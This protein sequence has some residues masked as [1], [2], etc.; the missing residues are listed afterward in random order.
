MDTSISLQSPFTPLAAGREFRAHSSSTL[1][2][3]APPFSP[4][5]LASSRTYTPPPGYQSNLHGGRL[6]FIS[7][8]PSDV[9]ES[10]LRDIIDQYG[11]VQQ[12][13]FFYPALPY[14]RGSSHAF[15]I[16]AS[17]NDALRA[18][19]ILDGTD[20]GGNTMVVKV[21]PPGGIP[22]PTAT[23]LIT[24]STLGVVAQVPERPPPQTSIQRP[25]PQTAPKDLQ[26]SRTPSP[27]TS[28]TPAETQISK[29]ESSWAK[30]TGKDVAE[31]KS[32]SI[33]P[34][35]ESRR[36]S[37]GARFSGFVQLGRP[38][39]SMEHQCRVVFIINLPPKIT[40]QKVSDA[41]QEGPVASIRFGTNPEDNHPYVGIIF[42]HAT[43]ADSFH[44]VLKREQRDQ[45][46]R[47]F[48]FMP[49]VLRGEPHPTDSIIQSMGPP[50]FARRRLTI[51]KKGLFFKWGK[52]DLEAICHK[53]VGKDRVQLIFLYN[54]GNATVCFS[55]VELASKV[56][57]HLERMEK[58]RPGFEGLVVSYSK[59]PCESPMRLISAGI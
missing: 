3:I 25:V 18:Q 13:P 32:Y 45:R 7:P 38:R 1:S 40:L 53:I 37:S 51:V 46:A 54:G 49:E 50:T 2:P 30:I 14:K 55:D 31:T 26:T 19:S 22:R 43:D 47:R 27:A 29:I 41:I 52:R 39:E 12:G 23:K 9:T 20:N 58:T 33:R 35:V 15:L 24:G 57:V 5:A 21:A 6:L 11:E 48:T 10:E 17:N 16:M 56:K 34:A 4:S 28:P 59:D 42:Q 44:L 36:R 8:I